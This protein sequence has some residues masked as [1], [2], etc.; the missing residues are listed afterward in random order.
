MPGLRRVRTIID[1]QKVM[2]L[3]GII[4]N[5][6]P[7]RSGKTDKGEWCVAEYLLEEVGTAYP[8]TVLFSVRGRERID[9]LNIKPGRTYTVYFTV[10]CRL[11][12]GKYYNTISAYDARLVEN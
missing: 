6:L 5:A 12:E 3:K 10:T 1:N 8:Q 7:E 11:H 4:K 2:E 9:R